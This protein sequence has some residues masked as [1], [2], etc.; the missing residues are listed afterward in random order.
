MGL[1]FPSGILFLKATANINRATA[2][3][4]RAEAPVSSGK[5][6]TTLSDDP[7]AST[8]IISLSRE[9]LESDQFIKTINQGKS[10]LETG[11]GALQ[12]ISE[13]VTRAREIALQAGNPS[14]SQLDREALADEV[15]GLLSQSLGLANSKSGGRYVF[16]GSKTSTSPYSIETTAGQEYATYHGDNVSLNL[17]VSQET[18]LNVTLPGPSVFQQ[19]DPGDIVF[20]GNTG[21]AVGSNPST[22]TGNDTLSVIHGATTY[23]GTTGI[24]AGTSSAAGDTII[25]A[26]GTHT[27]VV[28]HTA[29][30]L[31]LDGGTAVSYAGTSTPTN[32]EVT[33]ASGDKVYVNVSGIT[34]S[35]T[36]NITSTGYL[37][38]DGGTTQTLITYATNQKIVDSVTGELLN[39]NSTAIARAGDV[40]VTYQGTFDLFTA[41]KNLRDDLQNDR[42]LSTGD[43]VQSI[44]DRI[45]QFQ[46]LHDT[47]LSGLSILG[48]RINQLSL[49]E[50]HNYETQADT[51]QLL[52]TIQDTDLA[53]AIA[54]FT[55]A[56]IALQ[57]AQSVTA[58]LLQQNFADFL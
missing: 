26:S 17:L 53:A 32:F 57:Y 31:S 14:L 3:L 44:K 18:I 46:S 1:R 27:I 22:G 38:T 50:E 13:V 7:A 39:V 43:Q 4:V 51:K 20:T 49:T 56:Q 40:Y 29:Q 9:L 19:S 35:A 8:R 41:L 42:G 34:A 52:S 36:V 2:N 11:A 48:E 28:D 37:S 55:K 23:A 6:V 45:E 10:I 24:A 16:G 33:N 58:K 47:V 5:R 30:T 54:E 21:A 25:G 12:S 15:D